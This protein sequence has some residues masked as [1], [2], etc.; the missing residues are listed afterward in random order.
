MKHLDGKEFQ[1]YFFLVASACIVSFVIY[2]LH[3]SFSERAVLPKKSERY[4]ITEIYVAVAEEVCGDNA[5]APISTQKYETCVKDLSLEDGMRSAAWVKV[6]IPDLDWIL[7]NYRPSFNQ[8]LKNVSERIWI[9]IYKNLKTTII[10]INIPRRYY[11]VN[12]F[13]EKFFRLVFGNSNSALV[14]FDTRCDNFKNVYDPTGT[15]LPLFVQNFERNAN[16]V[17][18]FIFNNHLNKEPFSVAL[19]L[20]I[21][22]TSNT[23]YSVVSPSYVASRIL[24]RFSFAFI[25]IGILLLCLWQTLVW[26]RFIDYSSFLFFVS[27]TVL[28]S[29]TYIAAVMDTLFPSEFLLPLRAFSWI[30]LNCAAAYFAIAS[31]RWRVSFLKGYFLPVSISVG[32]CPFYASAL[33]PTMNYVEGLQVFVGLLP[34]SIS[35]ISSYLIMRKVKDENPFEFAQREALKKRASQ[36][37]FL[38]FGFLA[39]GFLNVQNFVLF[40]LSTLNHQPFNIGSVAA[41]LAI[42]ATIFHPNLSKLKRTLDIGYPTTEIERL[43]LLL[44]RE[45]LLAWAKQIREGVF[46][47]IDLAGSSLMTSKLRNRM[48]LIVQSVCE[49]AKADFI[50]RGFGFLDIKFVGDAV[51]FVFNKKNQ[52]I[53]DDV[54]EILNILQS[55][56]STY[57]RQITEQ[58]KFYLNGDDDEIIADAPL[59]IH[60]MLT[61][62]FTFAEEVSSREQLRFDFVS[63]EMNYMMK[64][65][66]KGSAHSI[67]V[68]GPLDIVGFLLEERTPLHEIVKSTGKSASHLF[69]AVRKRSLITGTLNHSNINKTA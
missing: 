37:V 7:D 52:L 69:A 16:E 41:V 48:H 22:V 39:F 27:S 49:N 55:E 29:I 40:L 28:V 5:R 68:S 26:K 35:F 56:N 57:Q 15:S 12:D 47:E 36:Q 2:A 44:N 31:A 1:T 53:R 45:S 25:F 46:V 32:I 62:E 43:K 58:L 63:E 64:Y 50:K 20:G 14:C 59:H 10:G 42:L 17:P 60:V 61:K 54:A 24:M 6:K 8:T 30:N 13:D 21:F 3:S 11:E 65:V 9:E 4:D 67:T 66:Q 23:L 18:A 34:A 38:G 33:P 19:D 51:I